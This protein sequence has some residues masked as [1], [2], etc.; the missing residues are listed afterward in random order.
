MFSI[1][2]SSKFAISNQC[3]IFNKFITKRKWEISFY[4]RE[5]TTWQNQ[6]H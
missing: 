4:H 6:P 3:N 1:V 2:K 5:S